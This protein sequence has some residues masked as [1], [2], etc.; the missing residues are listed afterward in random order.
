MVW[1]G[2]VLYWIW[3]QAYHPWEKKEKTNTKTKI[4]NKSKNKNKD[5]KE[6]IYDKRLINDQQND[7]ISKFST[8]E[9]VIS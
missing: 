6:Y 8:D 1:F 5:I 3:P 7:M 2:L 9:N 4:K